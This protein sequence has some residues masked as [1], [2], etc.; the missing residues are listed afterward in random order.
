LQDDRSQWIDKP[1]F[2]AAIHAAL[3]DK[4]QALVWLEKAYQERYPRMFQFRI[5]S[6]YDSL[7][8]DERFKA[9]LRRVKLAD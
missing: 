8:S 9:Y 4:E 2:L 7:R 6:R 1:A 5:D 3:G